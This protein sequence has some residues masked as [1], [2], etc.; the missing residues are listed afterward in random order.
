LKK[1][2]ITIKAV[3]RDLK[4]IIDWRINNLSEWRL[5][6]IFP[7]TTFSILVGTLMNN[8]WI[9]LLIFSFAVYHIVLYFCE[10]NDYKKKIAV[11]S[12]AIERG[13]FSVSVERL[14]HIA[15]ETIYE[16]HTRVINRNATR[17]AT[18]E[19]VVLYFKSGGSWRVP[20]FRHYDWSNDY[21]ISSNGLINMSLAGDEFFR[22]ALSEH[23]DI[24][25]CYLCKNFELDHSLQN[26]N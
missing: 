8:I 20:N 11:L 6:Y 22:I 10:S 24:D 7:I 26:G 12:D 2:I 16:P 19:I 9:G 18:K 3:K 25:Y 21:Y 23:P 1:E 15:N 4:K 14:S 17:N 13:D 5:A